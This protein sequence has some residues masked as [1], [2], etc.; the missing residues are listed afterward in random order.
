[1]AEPQ[2]PYTPGVDPLEAL[3]RRAPLSDRQRNGL[4]Q[5]YEA[6][7]NAQD[8]MAR[9]ESIQIPEQVK[10]GMFVLMSQETAPIP[11][12]LKPG[13]GGSA[14]G[15]FASN[16]GEMVNPLT[17]AE[18]LYNTV[19]HPI[20][21]GKAI[22]GQQAEQYHKAKQAE[23]EGRTSEMV[24]HS[25]AAAIPV[26]GP[27][28]AS[29]GEQMRSGDFA[30]GMGKAMGVIA[31]AA[32][33]SGVRYARGKKDPARLQAEAEGIV[34][35]KFLA[36][37]NPKYKQA[38]QE[39]APEILKRGVQGDRLAVQQFAEDL[40][41]DAGQ[42]IDD[43][44]A[45]YPP[46]STLQTAPVVAMLDKTLKSMTFDQP[47]PPA[48]PMQGIV[49]NAQGQPARLPAASAPPQVNPVLTGIYNQ[50]KELRDFVAQRGP[51]MTF[52]DMRRLRQQLDGIGQTAKARAK[53]SGDMGLDAVERATSETGNALRAQIA[54]ER[55]ELVAPNADM[56]LGLT[57]RDI[58]DP[59]R[60]RPKT[61]VAQ[62]GVTGGL[63][64]AG[65]IIGSGVSK[66]PGMQALGA[67]IMSDLL[68]R[69]RNAQ[70]SPENQLRLAQDKYRLA[71][72]LR[73]GRIR[74][75]Q[76]II[77]EM[78]VYVPGLTTGPAIQNR[79]Q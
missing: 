13:P 45:S 30:G 49:T 16:L 27:L 40:I 53:V 44:I 2:T 19:R 76:R 9:L 17:M 18:G 20:Q 37:G 11:S 50:I 7:A 34:A 24:G 68:P 5:I 78:A 31:P 60:G 65:A 72:A 4:W 32:A 25:V 39:V 47:T 70:L 23:A 15:R 74:P 62:T 69:I 43:V 56:H 38:A 66:I 77:R 28:A 29:A 48:N 51:T 42:R 36:P 21:T 41:A 79:P 67:F 26:I 75:A 14:V 71:E 35:D 3:L 1:M 73:H 54:A 33:L 52:D 22:I 57:L 64:T 12:E 6:S 10:Q 59:L 63:S 8:L 55:P 58:L 61:Q 46:S